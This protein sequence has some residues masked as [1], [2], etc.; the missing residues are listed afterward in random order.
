MKSHVVA[1]F[2]ICVATLYSNCKVVVTSSTIDQANKIIEKKIKGVFCNPSS[3]FCSPVLIQLINDGYITFTTNKNTTGLIVKFGNGSTIEAMPCLPSARGG[4]ANFLIADEF[5]LL[6]KKDYDEIMHPM[7]EN[8][9]FGGRPEDYKDDWE[10]I[11]LSSAKKKTNWGWKKLLNCVTDHFKNKDCG[12]FIADVFTAIANGINTK[13]QLLA[14]KRNSDEFTFM[15]EYCNIWLGSGANSLFRYEDFEKNQVIEKAFIPVTNLEY[16][17]GKKPD[18]TFKDNE[19]RFMAVDFAVATGSDN[20]RTAIMGGSFNKDTMLRKLEYVDGFNG[21]NAL[22]QV[23]RFKRFFYDYKCSFFIFDSTGIGNVCYDI[24]TQETEDKERGVTYPAWTVCRDNELQIVSDAVQNDKIQ[25][26][27]NDNAEE[28]MIPIVGEAKLNTTLH[29]S[30]RRNLKEGTIK[31]LIDDDDAKI[32]FENDPYWVTYE[33]EDRYRM[34]APYLQTR[35]M[36]NES[37]SVE[38]DIKENNTIKMIEQRSGTKDL[39]MA[40]DY[41]NY[42]CDKLSVKYQKDEN[43]DDEDFDM[44]KWYFLAQL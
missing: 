37:V 6:K 9:D 23:V 8:R 10:E 43:N 35:F 3:A 38:A 24:L 18:Y 31:F 4:R 17:D 2:A 19:I 34:L 12:F 1:L 29:L 11:F 44:S 39:F 32:N 33:S 27:I 28:V 25:R 5:V 40:L 26:T 42:F 21:V 22:D 14:A 16:L 7:L 36:I 15:Q 13:K 41:W 30:L 20:D